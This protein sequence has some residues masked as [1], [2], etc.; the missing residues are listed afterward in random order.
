M[1]ICILPEHACGVGGAPKVLPLHVLLKSTGGHAIWWAANLRWADK[2]TLIHHL[3]DT[4][5]WGNVHHGTSCDSS[6]GQR[7]VGR[8][9]RCWRV[10]SISDVQITLDTSECELFWFCGTSTAAGTT[11]QSCAGTHAYCSRVLSRPGKG[12]F[13][14]YDYNYHLF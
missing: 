4:S 6:G 7:L 5:P 10:I 12:P 8:M 3:A 13:L 14:R 1:N 9:T 11:M 2:G